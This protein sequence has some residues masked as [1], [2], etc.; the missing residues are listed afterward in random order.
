MDQA[1]ERACGPRPGTTSIQVREL[2]WQGLHNPRPQSK[3]TDSGEG[4]GKRLVEECLSP[5][6]L[7]SAG[8]SGA[9]GPGCRGLH[10]VTYWASVS[11]PSDLALLALSPVCPPPSGPTPGAWGNRGPPRLQATAVAELSRD[12]SSIC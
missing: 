8:H 3:D 10:A 5:A 1:R 4:L 6:R 9:G 11:L 2:S 12:S 7:V